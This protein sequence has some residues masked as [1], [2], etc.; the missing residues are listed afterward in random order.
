MLKKIFDEIEKAHEKVSN[1][2][3]QILDHGTLSDDKGEI[4]DFSRTIVIVISNSESKSK[5]VFK[6]EVLDRF[7]QVVVLKSLEKGDMEK[8]L[9]TIVGDF[10]AKVSLKYKFRVAVTQKVKEFLISEVDHEKSYSARTLK[11]AFIDYVGSKL[12]GEILA[13]G[14]GELCFVVI[15]IDPAHVIRCRN[16]KFGEKSDYDVSFG[17]IKFGTKKN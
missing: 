15:D 1:V 2:V 7:D 16:I 14:T 5:D 8:I 17:V 6:S 12:A 3:L 9:D 4:V 11:R 13:A 10:R